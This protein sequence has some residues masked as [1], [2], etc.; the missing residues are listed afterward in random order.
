MNCSWWVWQEADL[1]MF[2]KT[3]FLDDSFENREAIPSPH[4]P[5]PSEAS[6]QQQSE[7]EEPVVPVKSRPKGK[8]RSDEEKTTLQDALLDPLL[9]CIPGSEAMADADLQEF[10]GIESPSSQDLPSLPDSPVV[11]VRSADEL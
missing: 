3:G 1:D 6:Q 9:D 5:P 7:L 8:T 11:Q 4:F 2:Q 10:L